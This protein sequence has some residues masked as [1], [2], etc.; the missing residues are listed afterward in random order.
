MELEAVFP[1]AS[2]LTNVVE[3]EAVFL[4]P[5]QMKVEA[6]SRP[7]SQATTLARLGVATSVAHAQNTWVAFQMPSPAGAGNLCG[8]LVLR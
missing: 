6:V 5:V 8:V 4:P 3:V 2:Q 1:L 7:A